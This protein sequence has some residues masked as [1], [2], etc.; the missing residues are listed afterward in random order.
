MHDI[1][2][3]IVINSEITMNKPMAHTNNLVPFNLWKFLPSFNAEARGGFSD[4]LHS[5]HHSILVQRILLKFLL[6]QP[7]GKFNCVA[8][9]KQHIGK[10]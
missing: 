3:N 10:I 5:F 7:S 1:P 2:K 6:C 9:R 4:Y 8:C